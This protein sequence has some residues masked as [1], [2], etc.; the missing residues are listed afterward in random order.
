M[1][2]LIMC[3]AILAA[4]SGDPISREVGARCTRESDC[5]SRCLDG[6][7]WPGGF[8]SR[9]CDDSGGCPSETV[10]AKEDGGV[11]AFDCITDGD[12]DFLGASYRCKEVDLQ[13]GAGKVGICRGD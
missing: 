9:S 11:C 6:G 7:K 4:C 3:A 10:C 12:C 8:C 13:S 1:K 5:T 2:A